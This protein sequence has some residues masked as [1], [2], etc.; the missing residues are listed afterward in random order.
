MSN[1]QCQILKEILDNKSMEDPM[2]DTNDQHIQITVVH[3]SKPIE[4]EPR[5]FLNI[6]DNMDI[7]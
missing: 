3:N 7:K 6:N 1:V 5:K 4:I 2:K